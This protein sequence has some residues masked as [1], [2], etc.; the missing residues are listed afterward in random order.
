MNQKDSGLEDGGLIII[1]R[2]EMRAI[3]SGETDRP[4]RKDLSVLC[5][6]IPQ[7]SVTAR[8]LWRRREVKDLSLS[9]S[10]LHSS[11]S[12]SILPGRVQFWCSEGHV[13]IKPAIWMQAA[14]FWC[15]TTAS[16]L[17]QTLWT[18]PP[19]LDSWALSPNCYRLQF[20]FPTL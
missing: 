19:V 18:K 9:S 2:E 1:L 10:F 7:P 15:L 12:R 13:F 11:H 5:R 20:Q 17:L 3:F 14:Y 8:L 16:N 4:K 6:G